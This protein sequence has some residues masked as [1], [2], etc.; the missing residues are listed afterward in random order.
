MDPIIITITEADLLAGMAP[1]HGYDGEDG[2]FQVAPSSGTLGEA[3]IRAAAN[4]VAARSDVARESAREVTKLVVARAGAEID[5]QI[6]PIVTAALNEPFRATDSYGT[7]KGE[8]MTMR[9]LIATKVDAALRM[10]PPDGYRSNRLAGTG[11]NDT[12][13]E[14]FVKTQVDA[15]LVNELQAAVN[16]AKKEILG[17]VKDKAAQTIAEAIRKLAGVPS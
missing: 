5:R 7:A 1:I 6:E 4:I 13:L 17:L 15:A 8:P 11:G 9:A 12:T 3:V 16:E 10:R 2:E 14:K